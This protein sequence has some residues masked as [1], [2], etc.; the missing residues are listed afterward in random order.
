MDSETDLGD[1]N[2]EGEL[3]KFFLSVV[4]RAVHLTLSND[5]KEDEIQ[6]LLALSSWS[7]H[8]SADHYVKWPIL[9]IGKNLIS[10]LEYSLK[11]LSAYRSTFWTC[12][13]K[14]RLS[15][16]SVWSLP[17]GYS[18]NISRLENPSMQPAWITSFQRI[19]E[20]WPSKCHRELGHAWHLINPSGDN[21]WPHL[22]TTFSGS[23]LAMLYLTL[24][25]CNRRPREL[26]YPAKQTCP[27]VSPWH[28][29]CSPCVNHLDHRLTAGWIPS[30]FADHTPLLFCIWSTLR[31]LAFL[32]FLTRKTPGLWDLLLKWRSSCC[33]RLVN[34]TPILSDNVGGKKNISS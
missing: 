29:L 22:K 32:L 11:F 34:T 12:T 30:C 3:P 8:Q 5:G 26:R 13:R 4:N 10:F 18:W 7:Y 28:G 19:K 16:K 20:W 23:R 1:F 21:Y 25:L 31:P 33:S 14:Q 6:M 2:V 17:N 24:F 15:L 9:M 27:I